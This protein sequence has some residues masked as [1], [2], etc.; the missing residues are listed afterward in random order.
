[1]TETER[2]ADQMR[3]AFEGECWHGPAVLEILQGVTEQQAL[4]RPI[5][6]SHT[7]C[8]LVQH[9]TAWKSAVVDWLGGSTREVSDEENFPTRTDWSAALDGLKRAHATLLAAVAA[10]D[11]SRLEKRLSTRNYSV[12]VALHGLIQHDAYHSAQ[13]LMLKRAAEMPSR[14]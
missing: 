14:L 2:I 1:M 12:Y 4:A 13:I 11:D 5:P 3:R 10:L 8:E 9:L 7:I 6:G